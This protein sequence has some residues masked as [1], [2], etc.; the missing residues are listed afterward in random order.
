MP[1]LRKNKDVHFFVA[2]GKHSPTDG[3]FKNAYTEILTFLDKL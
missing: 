1:L 3:E 2:N